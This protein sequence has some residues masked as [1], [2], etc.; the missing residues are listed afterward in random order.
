MDDQFEKSVRQTMVVNIYN[1]QVG[2]ECM[3]EGDPSQNRR[4]LENIMWDRVIQRWVILLD[5]VNAHSP[6]WNQLCPKKPNTKFF[7]DLIKK[8]DLLI[9]NKFEWTTRPANASV[10]IIDLTLSPIQLGFLTLWEISEECL[11]LSNCELILLQW[12]N[13]GINPSKKEIAKPI[14]WNIQFLIESLDNRKSAHLNWIEWSKSQSFL[15]QRSD[16]KNLNEEVD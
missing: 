6:V 3:W 7:E 11:S 8:F 2:Q 15:D 4:V 5:Y 12:D 14:E 13:I 16:F 1:N 9:N 10:F